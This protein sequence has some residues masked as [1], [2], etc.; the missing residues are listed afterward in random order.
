MRNEIR[1]G[2]DFGWLRQELPEK[3]VVYFK[4]YINDLPARERAAQKAAR[5]ALAAGCGDISLLAE[6]DG[7][8]AFIVETE[9]RLIAAVDRVRSIPLLLASLPEGGW[10]VADHAEPLMQSLNLTI[11]EIKQDAARDIALAG[12]ALGSD[13]LYRPVKA[14]LPGEV[15][16]LPAQADCVPSLSS[17]IRRYALYR[18]WLV[19]ASSM[20]LAKWRANL[21]D[22]T[23]AI[24]EKMIANANGR[25]FL[26][27]L[28]AGLDSRLIVSGLKHLGYRNVVCFSY[29]RPGNHEADMAQ[30][31]AQRLGYSW[32]FLPKAIATIRDK[33]AGTE[34]RR[35]MTLAD[36]LTSTPVEA[37]VFTIMDLH[38]HAWADRQGII[39]N[40]QSGDYISGMHIPAALAGD[41]PEDRQRRESIIFNAISAKH[42]DLWT[43]L[44]TPENLARIKKRVWEELENAG[45][46]FDDPALAFSLYEFSEFQNRQAKYVLGN[47]RSYE[48][49]GFDW[50]LPLWDK[51]YLEFWQHVPLALKFDQRL[52]REMLVEANWGGVWADAELL[53]PAPR[54]IMPRWIRPLR[55]AAHLVCMPFGEKAWNV[56]DRRFFNY[57]T[58]QYTDVSWWRVATGPQHRNQVSWHTRRYLAQHGLSYTGEPLQG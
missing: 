20:D 50:R 56:A 45:A 49:F 29:G 48:V 58:L 9:G 26:C 35:Y 24:L 51:D 32:Y 43:K 6:L 8:F 18:P 52:Y 23:L 42:F 34:F 38:T 54:W 31:I 13:T 27:P 10:I 57:F 44:K 28:S 2:Q 19:E 7:H 36:H 15:A 33:Y 46:P 37:D 17:V 30:K 55:H 11:A 1:L 39:V 12:Y 41:L 4:G 47:Q 16:I 14:L 5:A 22:L 40:G 21:R 25:Q 3:G 53:P